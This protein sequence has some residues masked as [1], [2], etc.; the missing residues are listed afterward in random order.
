MPNVCSAKGEWVE[1]RIKDYEVR[2]DN[3]VLVGF[4]LGKAPMWHIKG[5]LRY[6]IIFCY[7][8]AFDVQLMIFFYLKRK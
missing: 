5:Y 4:K 8:V 2:S 6:E 3:N 7:K 1:D